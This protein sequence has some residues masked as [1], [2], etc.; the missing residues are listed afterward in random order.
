MARVLVLG[1]YYPP[2]SGGIEVNTRDTSEALAEH[3]DV[4][5]YCFNHEKGNRTDTINGV[6]VRRFNMLANVESQPIS[7]SMIVQIARSNP[8][9]V[10]FHAPNFIANAGLALMLM[11][12]KRP[13]I[14]VTHHTDVFGRKRLK[15]LL[16]PL[17]RFVLRASTFVLVTS[18][19]LIAISQD[20]PK[21]PQYKVIPLGVNVERFVDPAPIL[22]S[23]AT[24]KPVGFL[25]RHARYK[26]LSVLLK[27]LSRLPG[28]PARIG[29]DGPYRVEGEALVNELSIQD[30]IEFLG[31]ITSF[32]DKLA[33]YRSIGVFVFPSTEVTETF[34]IS[35]LEAMLMGVPVIASDLKTG[36]TDIAID[37]ETALLIEPGNDAQL[38]EAI[39]RLRTDQALRRRLID[40]ARQHVLTHFN[41][42]VIIQ[43]T[44][45]VFEEALTGVK[46]AKP[47]PVP[48][49]PTI[50][51]PMPSAKAGKLY[52]NGRFLTQDLTGVQ[53]YA[54]EVVRAL[55][56]LLAAAGPD[57]PAC[58]LLAP[59]GADAGHLD[60]KAIQLVTGGALG[61]HAWEQ[62]WLP[63]AARR[64]AL[65]NL[66]NSGPVLHPRSLT[67]IHDAI[68]YRKPELFSANYR[69]LHQT[70]GRLLSRRS[71]LATVSEFSR[72]ELSDV[73]NIDTDRLTVIP[74]G[75]DHIRRVISDDA[76]TARLGLERGGY[77]LFVGSP[78]PHKNLKTALKAFEQLAD[79]VMK[80]VVVGA[81]KAKVFGDGDLAGGENVLFTGRLTDGE[82]AGLYRQAKAFVFPSLYEGFGIPPLEAMVHGCPVLASD[83]APCSEVCADAA[84][85]F[86]PADPNA[87][88][89]AMQRILAEPQTAAALSQAGPKRAD[90]YSWR[91]SAQMLLDRLYRGDLLQGTLP[92]DR[93]A[94]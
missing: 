6:T 84:L 42:D 89:A 83:I 76:I 90:Y 30:R 12:G 91:Q 26:G 82:I 50:L 32:D 36:V 33:F 10:H 3:H 45:N 67:V 37:E 54:T 57:A 58:Q 20:L 40:N 19:K 61:G 49:A 79:P 16:M 73:L 14:V 27:A 72:R 46:P 66:C 21:G 69:R 53:R 81:A 77:F 11:L 5:V 55:D 86:S 8:D 70:L 47:A 48:H 28:V 9:L 35:Q 34:G 71:R 13:K 39:T 64:G 2:F 74:N 23:D 17:Y 52:I 87:L 1:K 80:F 22:D 24:S 68:I 44:V 59:K 18:G 78:A 15:A 29:G 4:T 93:I 60:L 7:L 94:E 75:A 25:S 62:S 51:P 41:N 56:A 88:T 92:K 85:F 43:Q 63:T 38:S 31:D 65:V